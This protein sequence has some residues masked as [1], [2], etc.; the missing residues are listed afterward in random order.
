MIIALRGLVDKLDMEDGLV[1]FLTDTVFFATK[2]ESAYARVFE[3]IADASLNKGRQADRLK[4]E[5]LLLQSKAETSVVSIAEILGEVPH[6]PQR[7]DSMSES[8]GSL[9]PGE[10]YASTEDEG[11]A[12]T[13]DMIA[14]DAMVP[15]QQVKG[16][17][18]QGFEAE[19]P[20]A[21]MII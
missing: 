9:M 4:A 17:G 1:A 11:E 15:S 12:Q 13:P 20:S 16:K 5:M 19:S 6:S 10:T 21:S 8:S 18:Q 2:D 7:S 14:V 3:G